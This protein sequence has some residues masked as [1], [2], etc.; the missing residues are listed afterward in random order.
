M[1]TGEFK[2]MLDRAFAVASVRPITNI[3]SPLLRELVDYS[4]STFRQ[5]EKS[6]AAREKENEDV[7]SL[8]LFRHAIEMA[9]SCEVLVTNSCGTGAI[10]VLR[11]EL[12][13]AMSLSYVLEKEEDY[14]QRSLAWF[15]GHLRHA[16]S[17]REL[18]EPG[19][20]T[21]RAYAALYEKEFSAVST[22]ERRRPN[23]AL[24]DEIRGYRELLNGAQFKPFEDEFTRLAAKRRYPPWYSLFDGPSSLKGLALRM[25]YGAAYSFL[26]PD[27]SGVSHAGEMSR[28]VSSDGG[29]RALFEP[30]RRP[31]EL[32]KIALM[33]ALILLRSIRE[34]SR[35]F[36]VESLE[37]WYEREVRPLLNQLMEMNLEYISP[38]DAK[39]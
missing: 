25:N 29:G 1:G 39:P 3:A 11:S 15:H 6:A 23:Q 33:S 8:V 28:Y 31:E 34:I 27:L 20:T 14:T 13:A 24:A 30:V 12:E 38:P 18:L 19:T 37:P 4:L 17:A 21:G 16:I 36:R 35:H 7:A 22:R 10:P 32:Q 5:C 26:Y 9:D 2:E